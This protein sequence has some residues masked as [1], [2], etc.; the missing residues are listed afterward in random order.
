[1]RDEVVPKSQPVPVSLKAAP[2]RN[3]VNVVCANP[4]LV[5]L[6]E[7]GIP[8]RAIVS[9]RRPPE[10]VIALRLKNGSY[11]GSSS[12]QTGDLEQ[13]V[14]DRLGGQTRDGRTTKVFDTSDE[15]FGK[16]SEQML[17]FFAE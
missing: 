1:M 15:P 13:H 11:L 14:H 12:H 2:T 3:H 5:A 17:S 9:G 7:P 8:R 6:D 10:V 4:V 16:T